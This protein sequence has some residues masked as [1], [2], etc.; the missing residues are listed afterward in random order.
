MRRLWVFVLFL[1][2]VP[3]LVSA[4]GQSAAPPTPAPP[5]F[6]GVAEVIPT[7]AQLAAQSV[8]AEAKV[9]NLEETESFGKPLQEARARQKDLQRRIAE[10]GRPAD[11][12][13]DRLL[14]I[15][16][17]LSDQQSALKR[18]LDG[19]SARLSELDTLNKEWLDK[20][21]YWQTWRKTLQKARATIPSDAFRQADRTIDG[22][23]SHVT[24]AFGP[25]VSLQRNVTKLQAQNL[26]II[27]EV[28][29]SLVALRGQTFKKT[30]P[31][32]FNAAYFRQFSPELWKNV[33]K[34]IAEVQGVNVSFLR[35]NAWLIGLQLLLVFVFPFLIRR[36][37]AKAAETTEWQFIFNHPWATG[38][39]VALASLSA[40]YGGAPSLW[41]LM[42]GGLAAASASILI[43]DLLKNPRKRFM[44]YLLATLFVISQGLQTISLPGPLYRLYLSVLSLL[45]IPLFLILASRNL[46]ARKGVNDGFSIAL[47]AG[48]LVLGISL[49]AQIG[50]H[51]T[52]SLRLIESSVKSVFV[53]LFS[54][55]V[56]R[57]GQGGI[58]FL[59][60][61]PFFDRWRFFKRFGEELT[62]RLKRVFH[63]LVV[64]SAGLYLLEVWGIYDTVSQAWTS[65]LALGFTV[66]TAHV[67]VGMA[68]YAAL[69]LYLSIAFSWIVR[70][71]LDA[72][73]FPHRKFDRG[74]RDS[75]KKLLHYSVVFIGFLLA[76][77][78]AGV[79]LKN[80]AV[81]AG[82]FG[83]GVG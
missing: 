59:L 27:N 21:T 10:L 83:I 54:A 2:M 46:K 67:T 20:R 78:V 44:V 3:G 53:G 8:A 30:S 16:N 17:R 43:G 51:S 48:A 52:L 33:A 9:S 37:R 56:I 32:L 72:E 75:I 64:V 39:F 66:G 11:W 24:R 55:M 28:D 60:D 36:Y 18:L 81:L 14:E 34:G 6:P 61:L 42:L 1:A 23:L 38:I 31:S 35:E 41:R 40:L 65:L 80:F 22:L 49:V 69:V 63:A 25:L 29:A 5:A 7:L 77:A 57:L 4:A 76:M 15:R 50:G 82:A 58:D 19:V 26:E 71:L 79:E 13:F 68:F 12:N 45:G 47:K 62:A 74:V 70:S 73:F